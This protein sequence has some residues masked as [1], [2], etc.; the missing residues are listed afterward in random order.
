MVGGAASLLVA[1]VISAALDGDLSGARRG[2]GIL[3][4]ILAIA[5]LA[6]LAMELSVLRHR[7][8]A[9]IRRGAR[10]G[11]AGAAPHGPPPHRRSGPRR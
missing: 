6:K 3:V 1:I 10:G 5:T 2:V 11:A 9:S 7:H 4:G 8:V